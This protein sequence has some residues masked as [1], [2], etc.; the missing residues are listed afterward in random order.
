MRAAALHDRASAQAASGRGCEQL[1]HAEPTRRLA[2]QS[3]A[4]GIAAE[5][6]YVL[7]HPFE[8]RDLIE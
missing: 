3:D 4:S 2:G 7:L 1:T 6:R 5:R 8:R